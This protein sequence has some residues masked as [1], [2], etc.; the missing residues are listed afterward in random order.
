MNWSYARLSIMI[1]LQNN[2]VRVAERLLTGGWEVSK[3]RY[4]FVVSAKTYSDAKTLSLVWSCSIYTM[5]VLVWKMSSIY[6]DGR[7]SIGHAPRLLD[8]IEHLNHCFALQVP[9]S[10]CIGTHVPEQIHGLAGLLFWS[11]HV[12][13]SC[14]KGASFWK[15]FETVVFLLHLIVSTEYY[16]EPWD[17]VHPLWQS[18]VGFKSQLRY[19][20]VIV[21]CAHLTI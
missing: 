3:M 12:V 4:A 2:L 11:A 17:A 9:F 14:P 10:S 13:V 5:F 16:S 8:L 15:V 7:E 19:S 18:S 21:F 1:L 6:A 20:M